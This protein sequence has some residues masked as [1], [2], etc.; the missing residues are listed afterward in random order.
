M[1]SKSTRYTP[2]SLKS[3]IYLFTDLESLTGVRLG[4]C[5]GLNT[6]ELHQRRVSPPLHPH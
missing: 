2:P 6:P 4:G 5:S 1:Y 3:V